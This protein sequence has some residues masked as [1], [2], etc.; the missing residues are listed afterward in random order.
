[1]QEIH[2]LNSSPSTQVSEKGRANLAWEFQREYAVLNK[3]SLV[4]QK[5]GVRMSMRYDPACGAMPA[6]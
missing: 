6:T 1:M 5:A 2:R 3:L 4:A